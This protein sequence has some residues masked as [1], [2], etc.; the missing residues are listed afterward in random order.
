MAGNGEKIRAGDGLPA[1]EAS[2]FGARAVCVDSRGNMY[3]CE[4]EGNGI[5]KVDSAGIMSTFAGTG[6]RGYSGDGG[7]A[8]TATWGAPKALRT[9]WPWVVTFPGLPQTRTCPH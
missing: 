6:E 7:P 4:R 9:R 2:L 1:T 8:L 5:R 3:I